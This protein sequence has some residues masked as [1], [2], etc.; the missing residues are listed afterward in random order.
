MNNYVVYQNTALIINEKVYA[1]VR[2]SEITNNSVCM[3]CQLKDVCIDYEDNHHLSA[4]CIPEHG[5]QKWFFVRAEQLTK[6]QRSELNYS[7]SANIKD[8]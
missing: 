5:S 2:E 6:F 1:L 3:Q 7:I 8:L 4:L